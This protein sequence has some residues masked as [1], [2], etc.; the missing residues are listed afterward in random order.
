[1]IDIHSHIIPCVDD[2]SK[3]MDMSLEI[4]RIYI[5]NGIN[6]VIATP[7]HIDGTKNSSSEDLSIG[8]EALKKELC[9]AE[10]P[11]EIYPGNEVYLSPDVINNLLG[12]KVLTLNNSR[13]ILMELPM[14]DIPLYFE[15]LI[16]E[17]LIK[18]YIPIIAHPER[19]AKII[20]DPN[21]LYKFINMG[22]LA[23]MNL[24]S[25]EGFYGSRSKNVAEILL[26]HNMIHFVG[27]DTHS[28][29][30]RSPNVEKSLKLL[31]NL[32]DREYYEKL[33]VT[34]AQV[35]LD[36]KLIKIDA[37]VEVKKKIFSFKRLST[38]FSNL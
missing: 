38:L 5:A 37:P 3:D 32:V 11:L 18:G 17:L 25:L 27:T 15:E 30:H 13:Y 20:K 1:M 19:N 8:L 7:H 10:I 4:A 6:K 22:A 21:S 26:G 14:N 16:Y 28:N 34:N 29:R 2:G 35:V 31:Y 9:I 12:N 23:Q 24:P 36:N 33:T